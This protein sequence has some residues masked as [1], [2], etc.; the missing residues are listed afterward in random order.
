MSLKRF[1]QKAHTISSSLLT[2]VETCVYGNFSEYSSLHNENDRSACVHHIESNV[3]EI[4][5]KFCKQNKPN[6]SR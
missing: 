3:E 6:K 1:N 2:H 5:R 4:E